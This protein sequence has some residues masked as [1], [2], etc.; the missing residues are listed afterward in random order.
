M[1]A[2][3]EAPFECEWCEVPAS[4]TVIWECGHSS[5]ICE[6]CFG[7]PDPW[8][9]D[10]HSAGLDILDWGSDGYPMICPNCAG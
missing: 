3:A 7:P 9:D 4:R 8:G 10:P 1:T 6:G 5:A 2:V